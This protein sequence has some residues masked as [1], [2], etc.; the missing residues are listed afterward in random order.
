M[1]NFQFISVLAVVLVGLSIWWLLL[2]RAVRQEI[3][4][5]LAQQRLFEHSSRLT[6][7]QN[8]LRR[9]VLEDAE[10]IRKQPS[11]AIAHHYTKD[12]QADVHRRRAERREAAK[13]EEGLPADA[14]G[15]AVGTGPPG[16]AAAIAQA[17]IDK[18]GHEAC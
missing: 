13:I 7:Q 9:E 4:Q 15:V 2:L 18:H 17:Y 5:A 14:K 10:I 8:Q 16:S 3:A 11:I 12:H 6:E 1:N